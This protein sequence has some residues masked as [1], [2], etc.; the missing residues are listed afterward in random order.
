[1]KLFVIALVG[2]L[3]WSIA[4]STTLR[5]MLQPGHTFDPTALGWA[6]VP[7]IAASIFLE[8]V[9]RLLPLAVVARLFGRHRGIVLGAAIVTAALF[10]AA[11]M[12]N[13]LPFWF[14]LTCQGV[15]GF[16]MNLLY[17]KVGGL[18]RRML[19]GFL[20]SLAFHLTFDFVIIVPALLLRQP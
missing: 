2:S 17:L 1:M 15:T 20:F 14:V 8:E 11:H 5:P 4:V 16:V 9:I 6:G 3:A 18:H 12:S 19:R 10:G 13:G 7:L